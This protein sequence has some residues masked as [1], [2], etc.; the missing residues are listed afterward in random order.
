MLELAELEGQRGSS[1][2][3]RVAGRM[4]VP[5]AP[6]RLEEGVVAVAVPVATS[7]CRVL[8]LPPPVV[9]VVQAVMEEGARMATAVAVAAVETVSNLTELGYRQRP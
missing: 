8:G 9:R 7:A 4:A 2:S 5:R 3:T 1:A 6:I